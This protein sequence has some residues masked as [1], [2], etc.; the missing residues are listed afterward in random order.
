MHLGNGAITPECA[1]ITMGAAAI[2]LGAATMAIRRESLSRE[3]AA[4]AVGL[5]SLVF[6]AQAI[7]VPVLPATSAHLVGGVLLAWV[8]GPGLGAGAMAIVLA[9]QA[10]VLGDGGLAALGANVLNMAL[11]PAGSV[12]VCR[13]LKL[14]EGR[15]SS[16]ACAAAAALSVPLAALL[17][18]G[19]T[20]LFRA[21]TELVGWPEFAYHMLTTHLWI[22]LAEG[23]LTLAAVG[24]IAWVGAPQ[25][26]LAARAACLTLVSFAV[27]A[28]PWSSSLPDG[29]ESAAQAA[30]LSAWLTEG[31]GALLSHSMFGEQGSLL[32]A[33][34]LV[35]LLIAALATI[36]VPRQPVPGPCS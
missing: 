11:L 20:A 2:G 24:A 9:V 5:G 26:A 28:F 12:A 4:L 33:T 35:G 8:L 3:K 1:A 21:S 17:I 25:R 29:Y 36:F 34:L 18:V 30:G 14:A 6:V 22:G 19:Q 7:N 32:V 31:A 23:G 16:A 27:A 15:W 13:Q 10:L